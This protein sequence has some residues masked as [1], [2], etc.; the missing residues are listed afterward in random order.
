MCLCSLILADFYMITTNALIAAI[1][2]NLQKKMRNPYNNCFIIITT[3][4]KTDLNLSCHNDHCH[5]YLIAI[6]KQFFW[7]S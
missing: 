4:I 6:N 2:V 1:D 7:C 5:C 3:I